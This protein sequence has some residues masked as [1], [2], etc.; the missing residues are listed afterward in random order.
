MNFLGPILALLILSIDQL[1]KW[2]VVKYFT[3]NHDILK[4]TNFFSID[5]VYN[6]G[7]SFGLFNQFAY[8][9][10]LFCLLSSVIICFLCQWLKKTVL[11]NERVALGLII[12]GAIGNVIDRLIYPGVIDFLVF[13]WREY[14]WPSFNIA[15]SAICLGVCILL[16][17]SVSCRK[18]EE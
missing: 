8:S 3:T 17:F 7:I 14:Y 10:Y 4:I 9:N 5:L 16:I 15:D 6:K 18:K 11:L 13:H 12:G 1:T 2:V